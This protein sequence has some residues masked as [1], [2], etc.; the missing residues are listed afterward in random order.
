VGNAPF[1]TAMPSQNWVHADEDG[2]QLGHERHNRAIGV[3]NTDYRTRK[4]PGPPPSFRPSPLPA[5]V[6]IYIVD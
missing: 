3:G 5:A 4:V 1:Q 6:Q 2:R